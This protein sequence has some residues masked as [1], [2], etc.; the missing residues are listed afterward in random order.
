MLTSHQILLIE[1][2][3]IKQ[4]TGVQQGDPL[5]TELFTLALHTVLEKFPSSPDMM[6]QWYADD[7]LLMAERQRLMTLL[8]ALIPE[9][10]K[11]GLHTNPNKCELLVSSPDEALGL[12]EAIPRLTDTQTWTY[13]GAPL[14]P[15]P[16]ICFSKATGQTKAMTDHIVEYAMEYP[17]AALQL[18][19][20]TMGACKVDYL[21]Q[22]SPASTLCDPLLN[23]CR[24]ELKR[25]TAAVL[26]IGDITETQWSQMALP[27]R[28][29]GLGLRDPTNSAAA[30]FLAC[31]IN[32]SYKRDD[33]AAP[34]ALQLRG[35]LAEYAHTL[36]LPTVNT[37]R[38]APKL[39]K[40]LTE[41]V[42]RLS[43]LTKHP[44]RRPP[45]C[46]P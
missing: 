45:A 6:Q 12:P 10:Q 19:K 2:T 7:G 17:Q 35:A 16:S 23:P 18:L 33:P 4:T 36:G 14:A 44:H 3:A 13:L 22:L 27:V 40:A 43:Y 32:M 20:H 5:A 37:P 24:N 11:I 46:T 30:A 34:N 42:Y 1:G 41:V 28:L 31:T 15:G 21:C 29:G 9:L 38:P 25:G 8:E 26:G 39:Q